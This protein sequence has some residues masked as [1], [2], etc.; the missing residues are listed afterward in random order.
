M[1]VKH[2]RPSLYAYNGKVTAFG[3][4]VTSIEYFDGTN[5]QMSEEIL[6]HQ[7]YPGLSVEVKSP[8]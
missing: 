8:V 3:G 7:Q 4:D 1:N 2:F 5:W 6:E